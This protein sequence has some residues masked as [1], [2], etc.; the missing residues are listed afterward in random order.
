[1]TRKSGK[2]AV[3]A[4]ILTAAALTA[5]AA[6]SAA[7][8]PQDYTGKSAEVAEARY[9]AS[10][11][12]E[13]SPEDGETDTFAIDYEESDGQVRVIQTE[14]A[15]DYSALADGAPVYVTYAVDGEEKTF[16]V[17]Y[18]EESGSVQMVDT[19]AD[20]PAGSEGE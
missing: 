10:V 17:V 12:G 2:L 11:E 20:A 5:A 19:A 14:G 3:T 1:M 18:D 7:G 16:S 8:A 6:V 13:Y 15:I 4:G 9:L